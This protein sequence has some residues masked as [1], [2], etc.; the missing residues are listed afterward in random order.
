MASM[1]FISFLSHADW[2]SVRCLPEDEAWS[3]E[4]KE[5]HPVRGCVVLRKS[6]ITDIQSWLGWGEHDPRD[7]FS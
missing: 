6:L 5:V 2:V 1:G 4:T 3:L 7:S